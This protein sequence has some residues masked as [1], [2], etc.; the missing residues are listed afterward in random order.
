MKKEPHHGFQ[1]LS[2]ISCA[3][4]ISA[5]SVSMSEDAK[6]SSAGLIGVSLLCIGANALLFLVSILNLPNIL[7]FIA[8][9][10]DLFRQITV[11]VG[12]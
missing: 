4:A 8:D 11:G 5:D 2:I 12:F 3:L 9:K 1:G 6:A 7:N 10:G